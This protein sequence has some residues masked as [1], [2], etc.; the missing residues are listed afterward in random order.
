MYFVVIVS[1]QLP[2]LQR[3]LCLHLQYY[4]VLKIYSFLIGYIT[5][6][7]VENGSQYRRL[8]DKLEGILKE[9]Y[10]A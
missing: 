6:M 9:A 7:L 8:I 4:S 2:G 1:S 10:V 3:E 5:A